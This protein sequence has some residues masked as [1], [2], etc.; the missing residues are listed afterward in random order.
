MTLKNEI[1]VQFRHTAYKAAIPRQVKV[2]KN[3]HKDEISEI[4]MKICAGEPS[5]DSGA[6]CLSFQKKKKKKR[7]NKKKSSIRQKSQNK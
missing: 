6:F 3:I 7:E 1:F 2:Y 5:V 4:E